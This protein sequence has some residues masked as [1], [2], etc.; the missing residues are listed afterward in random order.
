MIK[1]LRKKFILLALS[2]VAAVIV[3]I[4]AGIDV[5]NYVNMKTKADDEID[6][7]EQ[8]SIRQNIEPHGENGF[9]MPG[10]LPPKDL[11]SETAFA[12]RYFTVQ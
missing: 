12:A 2:V 3:V 9:P 7:V 10:V 11:P 6:F 1:K 5:A 8:N 4:V